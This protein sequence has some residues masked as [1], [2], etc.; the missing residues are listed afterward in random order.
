MAGY[1]R[2]LYKLVS[3]SSGWTSV[4]SARIKLDRGQCR[5][6]GR[7]VNLQVHHIKSFHMFPAMELDIRNTI[8]LCGRCHILIGHLDNW[9]SCNTEVIHDSHK[10]RWRIIARV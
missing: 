4:R 1:I 10:L 2:E 5:A 8:T 3:R 7:K 9:K 6:C